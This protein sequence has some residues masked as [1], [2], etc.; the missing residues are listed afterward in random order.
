MKRVFDILVSGLG[1]LVFAPLMVVIVVTIRLTSQGPALYRQRRTGLHENIFSVYK[2][3]TMVNKA[4]TLGTS[5]TTGKDPRITPIGRVLRKT[6]LDELPQLF[7]VLKGDMSFIGP[8]PDV[9]EITEKYTP[10]MKQVF[11]VRPGITS[12]AT[13][14]FRDEE[15]VLAQVDDPDRFYEE[16]V[17]P[18]KVE[19][20][21]EHARRNSLLFDL[22]ILLQTVW[23][24]TPPGKWWPVKEH[25]LVVAFKNKYRLNTRGKLS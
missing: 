5:V 11:A 12:L 17:V 7:N 19:L 20:A 23:A 13:L 15:E 4:D 6:K 8:R 9:P 18:L 10:E 16:A 24:L 1:I 14:H 21:K 22:K 3:R 2:F 25:D